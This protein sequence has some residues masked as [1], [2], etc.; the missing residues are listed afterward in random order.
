MAD[1]DST[2]GGSNATHAGPPAPVPPVEGWKLDPF[3]RYEARRWDGTAWT[4][5]V[6]HN[7]HL[8]DD[9][10]PLADPGR[11][12]AEELARQRHAR[13]YE[14]PRNIAPAS[15]PPPLGSPP[16]GAS[17]SAYS[18]RKPKRR[19]GSVLWEVFFAAVAIAAVLM[20]FGGTIDLE[21]F[22]GDD[23]SDSAAVVITTPTGAGTNTARVEAAGI[24]VD[25]PSDWPVHAVTADEFRAVLKNNPQF[26]QFGAAEN[27]A[28]SVK[29]FAG[30][31]G[32]T[33]NVTNF[34]D[35]GLPRTLAEFDS[36]MKLLYER[37]GY[38]FLGASAVQ[39]GD[40]TAYR[41]DVTGLLT[42]SDGTRTAVR[43]G[44]LVVPIDASMTV[45]TVTSADDAAGVKLIDDVLA[46]VRT[47]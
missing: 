16:L 41:I 22:T 44:Q 14:A 29:F 46:T 20:V 32:S 21:I 11:W 7:G 6:L 13:R 37:L 35:S 23:S 28:E 25:Y 1:V 26:D 2:A 24:T 9:P 43:Q 39:V 31:S 47:I 34:G 38:T 17:R 18:A 3:G 33:L 10:A 40:T 12:F 42:M 5:Q 15:P 45:V 36:V 30:G 4:A 19:G 27:A 8:E